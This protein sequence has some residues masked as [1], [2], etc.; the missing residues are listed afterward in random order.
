[1]Q[2]DLYV[3]FIDYVKAFDKVK[4][5]PLIEMK[6]ELDLDGKNVDL[7]MNLYWDQQAAVRWNDKLSNYVDIKSGV[8]QGC[9]LSPDLFS[10]YTELIMRNISEYEGI[11]VGG[12]NLNNLRYADDT[13]LM[14][15]SQQKLQDI[16][17]KVVEESERKG[18]EINKKKSFTMVFSKKERNPACKVTV[19]GEIVE[20]AQSF[21]YLRSV[22]TCDGRSG[23]EI[24]RRIGIA[25]TTYKKMEK[26]LNSRYKA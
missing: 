19:K 13:A 10:L 14:A 9:V 25:K 7:I 22:V 2:K 5:E 4:H 21:S 8:R 17:D 24:K 20:Q 23:S 26:V 18:L 16:L 15:D 12:V 11:K 3:C 6:K 1:M